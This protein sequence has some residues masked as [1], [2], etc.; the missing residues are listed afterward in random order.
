MSDDGPSTAGANS[1]MP[2]LQN[3]CSVVLITGFEANDPP[4][5]NTSAVLVEALAGQLTDLQRAC[6]GAE[7][8]TRLMPGDTTA[9]AGSLETALG[10]QPRPTHVLLLG[11]APGRNRVTLERFATNLRDFG[12]SDRQGNLPRDVSVVNGGPAAYCSTW[13]EQKR[14][15]E[16]LNAAGIP[17]A[18]SN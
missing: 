8:R 4:N 12:T 17:A 11:Q 6:G 10:E 13:P 5:R 16:A 18:T 14:L 3:R 2:T 7:V 1:T 15:I 9:L